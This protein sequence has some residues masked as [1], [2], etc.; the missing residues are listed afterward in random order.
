MFWLEYNWHPNPTGGRIFARV[1]VADSTHAT[2]SND[3]NSVAEGNPLSLA[4]SRSEWAI[5]C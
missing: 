1:R 5:N 3:E 4:A 2:Q